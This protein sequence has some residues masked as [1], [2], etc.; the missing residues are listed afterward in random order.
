MLIYKSGSTGE[1]VEL[2]GKRIKAHLRVS[3]LYDYDWEVEAKKLQLG[4]KI[5][6][7]GKKPAEHDLVIDFIGNKAE[8]QGAANHLFEVTERDIIKKKAGKLYLDDYYK[9]CYLISAKNKGIQKRNNVVQME[10]GVYAANPFWIK[11]KSLS[12][13]I[14]SGDGGNDFLEYPY[15]YAYDYTSQQK[16]LSTLDNDHY[17]DANFKMTIYGPVVN[18]VIN[19]GG[20]PYEVNTTVEANEYLV[21]DSTKNAVT[22]TLT[23]GTIVNEYNNRSFENS[24]FRPI[25]PGNHSVLWSGD[26]GWDIVLYQKRSEP[27]W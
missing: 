27:K 22:R 9:E 20:Y 7:F 14:F 24:V 6:S 25:P 8:R 21:I 19:I 18:P 1:V 13:P 3:D 17:A 4:T 2:S 16:G 23:D 11:E 10:M 26:F 15:D 12:Y 5:N